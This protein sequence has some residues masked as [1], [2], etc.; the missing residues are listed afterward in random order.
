ML[1]KRQDIT[2]LTPPTNVRNC[3]D[4][5]KMNTVS[6]NDSGTSGREKS[7]NAALPLPQLVYSVTNLLFRRSNLNPLP[8]AAAA[9]AAS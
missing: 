5:W 7:A 3:F 9:G 4:S 6:L 2:C 1:K 8:T